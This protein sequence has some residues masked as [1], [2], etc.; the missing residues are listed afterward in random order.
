M[1]QQVLADLD[2]FQQQQ[3]A[4]VARAGGPLRSVGE[5]IAQSVVRDG[6]EVG[7]KT[8]LGAAWLASK[9]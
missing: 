5:V 9:G 7:A 3:H 8:A 6:L 4:R 2:R 1:L